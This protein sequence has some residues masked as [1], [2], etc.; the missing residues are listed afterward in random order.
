ML[1]IALAVATATIFMVMSMGLLS[2]LEGEPGSSMLAAQ[3]FSEI[4]AAANRR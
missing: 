2:A 4:C 1:R 3:D